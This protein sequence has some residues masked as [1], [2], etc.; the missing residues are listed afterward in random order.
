MK[1]KL[2]KSRDTLHPAGSGLGG[3]VAEN[4]GMNLV[5]WWVMVSLE[6]QRKPVH[7]V[8]QGSLL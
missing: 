8:H 1:V 2:T 6:G 5:V 7:T 4:S 3:V